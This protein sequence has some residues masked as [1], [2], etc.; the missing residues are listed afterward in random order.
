MVVNPANGHV[1]VTV[2]GGSSEPEDATF[3]LD[4]TTGSYIGPAYLVDNAPSET[5][6]EVGQATVG[7]DGTVYIPSPDENIVIVYRADEAYSIPVDGTPLRVA[8][9]ENDGHVYA[10]VLNLVGTIVEGNIVIS[11]EVSVVDLTSGTTIG[12]AYNA[13]VTPNMRTS[14][15]T[16]SDM[17]VSPDGSKVYVT[18]PYDAAVAVID[19]ASG[20]TLESI[21]VQGGPTSLAFNA[22]GSRLYVSNFANSTVTEVALA[23]SP[24]V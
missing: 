12:K 7:Q 23:S 4:A 16:F 6:G 14:L 15:L 11:Y 19:T 17:A 1:Y 10:S 2:I 13:E 24:A 8:V 5:L 9:N 18:R 3:V 21:P 20:E 22:D